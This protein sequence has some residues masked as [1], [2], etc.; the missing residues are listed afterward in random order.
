MVSKNFFLEIVKCLSNSWDV[1]KVLFIDIKEYICAIYNA[2]NTTVRSA[3]A[4]V[5]TK[6]CANENKIIDLS[7]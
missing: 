5:F 7:C 6:K 3:R 2:K 1:F 4:E